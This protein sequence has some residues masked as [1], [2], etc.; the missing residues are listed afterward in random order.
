MDPD[1]DPEPAIFVIDLQDA[2]K[3]KLKKKRF[4]AYGFAYIYIVFQ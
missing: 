2:N 4:S 1:S 3:K